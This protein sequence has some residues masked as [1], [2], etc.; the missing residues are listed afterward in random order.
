MVNFLWTARLVAWRGIA[1]CSRAT[2]LVAAF[3]LE[4]LSGGN[5]VFQSE[6]LDW[7]NQQHIR[8]PGAARSGEA[9]PARL[10]RSPA[11]GNDAYLGEAARVVFAP[12][13]WSGSKPRAKRLS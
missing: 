10:T 12:V 2:R 5:A 11:S 6:K 7:F 8:A 4:G 1:S 13:C 3:G 9:A